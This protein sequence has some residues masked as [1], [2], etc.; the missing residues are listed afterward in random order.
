VL[1]R[2][3]IG[4]LAVIAVLLAVLALR[5]M[6]G[7]INL[8]F[9]KARIADEFDTPAGKL[10]AKADRIYVEWSSISQP[11]RLVA[12]GVHVTDSQMREVATAPSVALTFEP[13]SAVRG[14]FLPRTIVILRPT[15]NGELD[16]EGGMLRRILAEHDGSSQSGVVDLLIDQLL[17]EPNHHSLLG[18][19]DTVEVEGA[20]VALRDVPSGVTWLAPSARAS[21]KRDAAGVIIAADARFSDGGE[22]VDVAVSGT[23]SRDRSRIRVE[24][25]I[26]GLKPSML[27]DLSPDAV[28][29]RGVDIALSG[30]LEIEADGEGS[31][32]TVSMDVTG[33]AGTLNL[34]GVLP[35]AHKVRS[36]NAHASIDADSHTARISNIDVDL[37]VAKISVTGDGIRTAQ[38]QTFVGRAEIRNI[39]I[40]HLADY[41]P[42]EF[43][44]GGREWALRNLSG[45]S[46]DVAAEFGL[47]TP[48]DDLSQLAVTR[49][50][51]FLDFR[52]MTV[53]YMS[54][55]PELEGVSGRARFENG[56][57]HFD[58]DRGSAVGLRVAGATVDLTGLSGPPPHHASI[59]IPITGPAPAVMALLARP[60]LGLPRD[61]LYDP[62]RL[63]GEAEIDLALAFPLINAL[64]V[65]EIDVKANASL[66]GFSLKGAIGNVDLTEATGQVSYADS[67]LQVTGR[68]KI[69]GN[70]LEISRH[71]LFAAK[72]PYRQR[73][74]IKGTV[75]AA[76]LEKAGFPSPEPYI[77]GPVGVTM[78]YQENAG[79]AAELT[80]KFDLKA[81]KAAV[82]PLGWSKEAGV[83][84]A[85]SLSLKLARGGKLASADFDSKANGLVVKGQVRFGSDDA[86]QQVNL[87]QIAIGRTDLGVDW[88]RNAGSTEI[89]LKGRALEWGRVR[90]VMR[91]REE[92]DKAK[93]QGQVGQ[94]H[95]RISISL[96]ID[97][98]LV[99]RGTLGSAAGHIE[100]AGDRIASADVSVSGGKGSA[101]R[102]TPAK[103]P[104][105]AGR[106]IGVYVP[107]FGLLL[108]D[109]G[110]LDGFNGSFFD[111]TGQYDD[112]KAAAPLSGTL[113]LGPYRL[114]RVSPRPDIGSLN[115]TIDGLNRAGD[116]SQQF[117]GLEAK[118]H[119]T[120][121]RVDIRNART[122][123]SSIGLTA[124]GSLDLNSETARLQGV[125]VPAFALNNLLSNVPL[126]GPLLTGGKGGGL[127][128]ISYRLNGPFDDLKLDVNMM[129]AVTP[130]VLRDLFSGSLDDGG[131]P[132]S[133]NL[134]SQDKTP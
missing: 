46:L 128:A 47:A 5:L 78:R 93:G 33:G 40:D 82:A 66:T 72:V 90:Q 51:A 106:T 120:G 36:V 14:A 61:A 117:T 92:A 105:Q 100:L 111:F 103:S 48:G 68:G 43:A 79:G 53:H 19:L 56:T 69:D 15:F 87:L 42:L 99:E 2:A 20:R 59:H 81:A 114:A 94:S 119:K 89:N 28:I 134:P 124:A 76:L 127:F 29:L 31:V 1:E 115:S 112:S 58:I 108:R 80:G 18:Q 95:D 131:P 54:H 24:A 74:D 123:G 22:P 3:V 27:A 35:V 13:R 11:I 37:G 63:S 125:V 102:V 4:T 88:K 121:D 85:L 44:I 9:L 107:D 30:R 60:Q 109:A 101:F 77:S 55:M 133:P 70:P 25:K 71:E 65:A 130:G 126:L 17:A 57:L 110:W 97:Q 122:S 96:Q 91:A 67:E 132:S 21:L 98:L 118:V 73:Y 129:S 32:K 34:P 26:D 45:G 50:V 16:R 12:V 84:G 23:Y 6:A 10:Q 104:E 62:K 8:D 75:P 86:V 7:P 38:G 52:G 64:T 49:N 116:P 41:W 83:D 39:P 113:R